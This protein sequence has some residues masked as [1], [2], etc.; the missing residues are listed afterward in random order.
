MASFKAN[1]YGL[2]VTTAD[3]MGPKSFTNLKKSNISWLCPSLTG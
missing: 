2:T 3:F 1:R